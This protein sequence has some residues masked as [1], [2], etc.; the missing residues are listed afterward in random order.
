MKVK[1]RPFVV[2]G[3][4]LLVPVFI[5]FWFNLQVSYKYEVKDGRWFV[6]TNKS[7]TKEQKDIQYKS[8]DKLE[9]DINRSS[10]LLLILAG[11]TL[12]TA[13]FL[14]FKSEKTA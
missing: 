13:T 4:Y 14:I 3:L 2:F 1:R 8:I 10:I 5:F 7:L 6:E 11:T 12:F 9:K